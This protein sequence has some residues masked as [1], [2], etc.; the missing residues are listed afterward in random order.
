MFLEELAISVLM[1]AV[2]YSIPADLFIPEIPCHILQIRVLLILDVVLMSLEV[3]LF[4]L[5]RRTDSITHLGLIGILVCS[6]FVKSSLESSQ[7]F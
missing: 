1:R 6:T 2:K 4:N 7:L 5:P 3:V